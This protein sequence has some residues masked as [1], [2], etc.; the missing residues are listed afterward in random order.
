M[1]EMSAYTELTCTERFRWTLFAFLASFTW[2]L[3]R[4]I[5]CAVIEI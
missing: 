5:L 4:K 2:F 1:L 3:A